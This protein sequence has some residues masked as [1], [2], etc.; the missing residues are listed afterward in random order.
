[1]KVLNQT[2]VSEVSGGDYQV[3]LTLHVPGPVED[4]LFDLFQGVVTGNI[5]GMDEFVNGLINLGP[6]GNAIRLET[7]AFQDFN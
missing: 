2:E 6:A 3:V 5:V 4:P 1:M 7:V